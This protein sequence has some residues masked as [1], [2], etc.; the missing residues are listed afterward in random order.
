[1][2][3]LLKESAVFIAIGANMFVAIQLEYFV[4]LLAAALFAASP[5]CDDVSCICESANVSTIVTSQASCFPLDQRIR[6]MPSSRLPSRRS[7]TR[8]LLDG[9][10]YV[11][12]LYEL[13]R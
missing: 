2:T 9:T 1:M 12:L 11:R 13:C 8:S 6:V 4:I 5:A 3:M 10:G 7:P